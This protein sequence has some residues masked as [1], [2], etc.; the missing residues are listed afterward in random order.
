VVQKQRKPLEEI[1]IKL[2]SQLL[3]KQFKRWHLGKNSKVYCSFSA[4]SL[5][6]VLLITGPSVQTVNCQNPE[7]SRENIANYLNYI[8]NH[9]SY[10][11]SL[12][13]IF[14]LDSY[15]LLGMEI[16]NRTQVIET[17]NSIQSDEG[18]WTTGSIHYVP[19]TAQIL[20]FYARSGVKPEKSLDPFFSTIDTWEKVTAHVSAYDPGNY[21]GGLWGYVNCYVVYK[22]ESPPWV[23]QFVD[24]ANSKIN[25]WA[26]YNHQR[27]HLMAN[28]IQLGKPIPRMDDVLNL[29]LQQQ[30]EDGSWEGSE[31]ETVFSVQ[32]LRYL[33]NETTLSNNLIDD[34]MS[35]AL[36]YVKGCYR[37]IEFEGT[38][39]AG[40]ASNS[41]AQDPEPLA[42]AE[43]IWALLNP[44][45]DVWSRWF[46][47]P[48]K[49]Y[50][51]KISW[52]DLNHTITLVSSSNATAFNFD[53]DL[54]QISFNVKNSPSILQ[55]CSVTIPKAFMWSDSPS[56]WTVTT[57]D[58]PANTIQVT[59]NSTHTVLNVTY[60]LS[61]HEVA[62]RA[63]I[64]VPEFPSTAILILTLIIISFLV[65]LSKNE[66]NGRKG[67][68][69]RKIFG[70]H[71]F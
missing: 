50:T 3:V 24:E 47:E 8:L 10:M 71:S 57:D 13:V 5:V 27:T 7:I 35:K 29:T 46:V 17:L 65:A 40:F 9:A 41:T 33:R 42:T 69:S 31:A 22:G 20:M 19:T 23:N 55:Y 30:R 68:G 70:K 67:K 58:T 25:T 52:N 61:T 16:P 66:T 32:L 54:K 63:T 44:D 26:Y 39:Y 37:T 49:L 38:T 59:E 34:A 62:I 11:A 43:G 12:N 53:Y 21:W 2:H 1:F 64:I 48:P 14:T 60:D 6:V 51:F 15:D 4:L 56:Q 18:T 36:G 28:L 45:S